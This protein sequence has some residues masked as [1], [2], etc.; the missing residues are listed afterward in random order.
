MT[1]HSLAE[2]LLMVLA[3]CGALAI[4]CLVG[5]WVVHLSSSGTPPGGSGGVTF[6]V[7][8]V[9]S[10]SFSAVIAMVVVIAF[11]LALSLRNRRR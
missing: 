2:I 1:R 6:S 8:R 3:I 11:A 7:S 5:L 10:T 4:L 9:S